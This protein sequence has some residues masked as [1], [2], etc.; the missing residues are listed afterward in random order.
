LSFLQNQGDDGEE[1]DE[2]GIQQAHEKAYGQGDSSSLGS[3]SLG[4][5]GELVESPER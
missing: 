3:K 4:A 5:A 1:L 2:Q